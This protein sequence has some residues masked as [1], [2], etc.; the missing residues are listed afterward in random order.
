MTVLD[1]SAL[2]A[3]VQGEPGADVVETALIAGA[4]CSAANW[5]EVAQKVLAANRDWVLV[6]SLLVCYDIEVEPVVTV[7]AEWAAHRWRRKENL[8]LADRLCL[9]LAYRLNDDALTADAAW[10]DEP[11]VRVIR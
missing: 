2:L 7:D 6:R 8:S 5:S 11:G 1:A 9:A 4:Q 10:A 3:F